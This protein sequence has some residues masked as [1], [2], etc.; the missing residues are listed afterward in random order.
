MLNLPI[1]GIT[2][3]HI[4]LPTESSEKYFIN[5]NICPKKSI[6]QSVSSTM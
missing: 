6:K 2:I 1:E 3:I 4:K 5:L